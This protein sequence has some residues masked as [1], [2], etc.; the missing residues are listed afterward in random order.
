MKLLTRMM[1]LPAIAVALV[2]T[3]HAPEADAGG[4][5]LSVGGGRGLN[6][7]SFSP[8]YGGFGPSYRSG[9]RGGIG[10]SPS[11][12]GYGYG[13]YRPSYSRGYGYGY[14][15]GSRVY[16]APVRVPSYGVGGYCPGY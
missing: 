9:Y 4:F 5:S 1:V 11:Y 13:S 12:R 2:F 6:V 14:G 10:Y 16:R 7:N 15:G 3:A 8:Y